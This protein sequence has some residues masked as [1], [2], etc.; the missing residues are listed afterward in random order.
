MTAN[1]NIDW[2]AY[3]LRDQ[4]QFVNPA[5]GILTLWVVDG[6][7]VIRLDGSQDVMVKSVKHV[8]TSGDGY[9][10]NR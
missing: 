3:Q 2:G 4:F 9:R 6:A 8:E 7:P 10:G 5:N 1:L